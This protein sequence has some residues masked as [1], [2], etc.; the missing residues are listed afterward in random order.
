MKIE[1]YPLTDEQRYMYDEQVRGFGMALTLS[2]SAV[3]KGTQSIEKLQNAANEVIRI[4]EGVR[5]RVTTDENNEPVQFVAPFQKRTFKVKNF[6]NQEELDRFGNEEWAVLPLDFGADNEL[7]DMQIVILPDSYGALIRIHHIIS[8]AWTL[9][10]I[11]SQFIKILNGENVTSYPFRD[12]VENAIKYKQS[13][14]FKKDLEFFAQQEKTLPVS[15]HLST[16]PVVSLEKHCRAYEMSSQEVATVREYSLANKVA[17]ANLFST[18]VC[19][20]M[21]KMLGR[22][23]FYVGTTA[24]NRAGIKEKN[25]VGAFALGVAN[26]ICIKPEESFKTALKD[27]TLSRLSGYRHQK[28][29][30]SYYANGKEPYD[31]WISYQTASLDGDI[32]ARIVQY[33]QPVMGPV[34]LLKIIDAGN[35]KIIMQL[36]YNAKFPDQKAQ[37][38]LTESAAILIKGLRN[39]NQKVQ[40]IIDKVMENNVV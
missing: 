13:S 19:I 39:D 27:V 8:D 38:M 22:D 7:F 17:E 18:A 34:M 14:R 3:F 10:L 29:G 25:T 9:F 37:R 6:A 20:W 5:V 11:C 21:S 4:N 15:T 36:E 30:M 12:F 1:S 40:E 28:A 24:M 33:Q 31:L 16:E 32:E 2:G 26:R 35:D 23:D